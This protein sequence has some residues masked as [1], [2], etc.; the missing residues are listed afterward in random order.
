MKKIKSLRELQEVTVYIYRDL[1]DFCEKNDLKVYLLGGS[2]IGALRHKGYIPWDDDIDV[3][4][5]RPDYEKLLELSNGKISEKCSI[6]DPQKN[7]DFKGYI[8][9]AVYDNSKLYSGQFKDEELKI[10]VSIFVYDGAPQNQ[11]IRILYYIKMYVLRAEVALCRADFRHVN[12][13]TAKLLGPILSPFFKPRSVYHYKNKV[14]KYSKKYSYE[15]NELVAPN[16]DA[17]AF[18]EVYPKNQF[19]KSVQV[20]FEGIKSYAF[21]YYDSHLKKYYGDYMKL[22]SKEAQKPKHSADAWVEDTFQFDEE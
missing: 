20:E 4:M 13:R 16:V 22:P 6:I 1:L 7:K 14:L 3:C 17:N 9:L 18:K 8:P 21:S 12:T 2:L 10:S 15:G 11:V 5:S 19:E